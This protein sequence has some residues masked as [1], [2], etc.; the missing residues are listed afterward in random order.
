MRLSRDKEG[1]ISNYHRVIDGFLEGRGRK[2]LTRGMANA[3]A[4][5][6][7]PIMADVFAPPGGGRPRRL[8]VQK[9]KT[10]AGR[11]LARARRETADQ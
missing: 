4:E 11:R 10:A 5:I 2:A 6:D 8:W 9:E 1:A 7:S 3:C